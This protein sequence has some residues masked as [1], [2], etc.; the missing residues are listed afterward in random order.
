VRVF[1][2]ACQSRELFGVERPREAKRVHLRPPQRFV[3]IDVP[4]PCDR[5]L[6]EERNLDRRAAAFEPL[7]EL[8]DRERTAERLDAEPLLEV[9]LQLAGLE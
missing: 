5:S 3:D 9:R 7:G 4:E 2:R 8:A 6:I 1:D